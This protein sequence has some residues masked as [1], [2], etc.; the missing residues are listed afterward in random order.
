MI[1]FFLRGS[2][3]SVEQVVLDC[4]LPKALKGKMNVAVNLNPTPFVLP[5]STLCA[6]SVDQWMLCFDMDLSFLHLNFNVVTFLTF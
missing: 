1:F 5:G 4:L 3:K 6:V 2:H